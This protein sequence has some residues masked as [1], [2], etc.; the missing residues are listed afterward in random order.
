MYDTLPLPVMGL[1]SD[2]SYTYVS[3]KV[4]KMKAKAY[5]MGIDENMD[6]FI[7]LSFMALPVIPKIRCTPRGIFDVVKWDFVDKKQ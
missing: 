4:K 3:N 2:K 7:T 5:K 1:I 6:P